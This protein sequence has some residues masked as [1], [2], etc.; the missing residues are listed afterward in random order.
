MMAYAFFKAM[1]LDGDIGTIS[2]SLKWE[3]CGEQVKFS[4]PAL[5]SVLGLRSSV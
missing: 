5:A 1:E 2:Q 4:A 3:T